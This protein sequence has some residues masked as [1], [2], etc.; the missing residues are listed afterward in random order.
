MSLKMMLLALLVC[1]SRYFEWTFKNASI[2]LHLFI[3]RTN[4]KENLLLESLL[5]LFG[6]VFKDINNGVAK[7]SQ[8]AFNLLKEVDF[9]LGFLPFFGIIPVSV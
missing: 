8:A 7:C 6:I 9:V 2:S 3:I 4:Y 5:N 1:S